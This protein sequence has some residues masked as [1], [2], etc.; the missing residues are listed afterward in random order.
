MPLLKLKYSLFLVAFSVS[1]MTLAQ[2]DKETIGSETVVIV[3][4]YTPS[5]SDAFK[6][7]AVPVLNDSVN[8]SKKAV[9][10]KIFSVPVASTF[11]PAKG[12]AAK[13]EK[14]K[15]IKAFDNYATLG[16]GNFTSALAEFY[17]NFEIDRGRNF[18]INFKHNSAQG[19]IK[20][21]RLDD[22]YYDTNLSLD[23]SVR[24][25]D[26]NYGIGANVVHKLY[27]W[28]G[29]PDELSN[30]TVLRTD[31][32]Q[33]YFGGGL[34]GRLKLQDGVLNKASAQLDY[35]GDAHGTTEIRAV[36][37]PEFS[38]N[39]AGEQIR[40]TI[41][42]DYLNGS[43]EKNYG[44][45]ME[46]NYS[47]LNLGLSPSILI[48][49]DDLELSLGASVYYSM[50]SE[51]STSDIFVYPNIEASYRVAG[52]YFIA[53]A[54]LKGD[55]TQNTYKDI[56]S[57]NP[58][59]SPTLFIAPTDNEYKATLGIKGK[60]SDVIS[61][62]INGNYSRAQN[63]LLF[64]ANT[65]RFA[66]GRQFED[67]EYGNSFGVVYDNINTVSF[68]GELNFD[69]SKTLRL[70]TNAEYFS[71]DVEFQEAWNLP[72]FKAS[73]IGD[74]K[75]TEKF[76]AGASLFFIGERLD[77]LSTV[78]AS[79]N[80]TQQTETLDA[81]I[82]ANLKLS[83]DFNPQLSFFLKG[84]NL[85]SDNYEKWLNFPV[86]GIQGLAGATYKFDW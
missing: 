44:G 43:F 67:Y 80:L 71:Y 55:L 61:Y 75:I 31:A 9:R 37:K 56:V 36:F 49:R 47:I 62:N 12:A 17:T 60:L 74:V 32:V 81:Y 57:T 85:L 63:Q 38:F 64:K 73:I 24:E 69:I 1:F 70:T 78:D 83:Y 30:A 28:Y 79:N 11:T 4:P 45:N 14:A 46:L 54:G 26:L 5:V 65:N 84:N 2:D 27:N 10:Y 29:L 16:A 20:E 41:T 59:V 58:F 77:Q 53:Y 66:L 18:G 68:F 48:L 19:G 50:D 21:V 82:D 72:D 42:A 15:P 86:Y 8:L 40:T 6:V 33:N 7:K 76:T 51:N 39:I 35:F 23:Y 13:V 34:Q 52:E 25:R 22:K 3:K